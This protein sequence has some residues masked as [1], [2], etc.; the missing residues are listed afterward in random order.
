MRAARKLGCGA[1]LA[2]LTLLPATAQNYP[3][4]EVIARDNNGLELRFHGVPLKAVHADDAQNALSIDFQSPVD[5][6]VFDR[7]AGDQ[8]QWVAMSYAN[9][10][11]GVIRATRPVT[12]LTRQESDGFSLKMVPR[13][14]APTRTR[15][16][17]FFGAAFSLFTSLG[18]YLWTTS[19]ARRIDYG[20]D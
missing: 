9:Y 8:P 18:Y 1:A 14:P 15:L 16:N 10:D 3:T 4:Y 11:N 19:W 6:A 20:H 13:G 17:S 12:F 5:G 7:L 2:L